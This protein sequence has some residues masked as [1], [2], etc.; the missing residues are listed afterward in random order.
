M[1][2]IEGVNKNL[3]KQLEKLSKELEKQLI[4]K[5]EIGKNIYTRLSNSGIEVGLKNPNKEENRKIVFGS[6]IS[7]NY[8]GRVFLGEERR[9]E[10]NFGTTGSFTPKVEGNEGAIWRTITAGEFLRNWEKIEELVIAFC[11]QYERHC[12]SARFERELIRGEA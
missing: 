8:S 2:T 1:K 4:N 9:V 11:L 5:F 7:F 3:R 12:E 6:E 10:I